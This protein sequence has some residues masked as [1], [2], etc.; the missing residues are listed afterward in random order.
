M[1]TTKIVKT[2]DVLV[3]ASLIE[4]YK[5]NVQ[6]SQ[7]ALDHLSY[8]QRRPET[9]EELI[10]LILHRKPAGVGIQRNGR[11]AVFYKE[12]DMYI[13]IIAQVKHKRFEII[14]FIN[15]EFMPN[16]SRI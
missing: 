5:H 6:I 7:H 9:K 1:N 10:S 8:A 12:S 4:S 3:F 11:Y 2:I 14:T 15:T 16:L 13:K